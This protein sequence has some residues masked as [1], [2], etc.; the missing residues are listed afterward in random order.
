MDMVLFK[1]ERPIYLLLTTILFCYSNLM[2]LRRLKMPRFCQQRS[3]CGPHY[4]HGILLS[5][6]SLQ[7]LAKVR[8]CCKWQQGTCCG[9]RLDIWISADVKRDLS[10]K[11]PLQSWPDALF[12]LMRDQEIKICFSCL[13]LFSTLVPSAL[14]HHLPSS[15]FHQVATFNQ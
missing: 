8:K 13:S 1:W 2:L 3:F 15:P 10:T 6:L 5:Y 9:Q 7:H 12:K 11:V 14:L 4:H